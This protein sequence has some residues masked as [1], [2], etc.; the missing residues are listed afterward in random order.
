MGEEGCVVGAVFAGC[1]VGHGVVMPRYVLDVEEPRV[2][3]VEPD[4]YDPKEACRD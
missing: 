2:V 4:G 3:V 1:H